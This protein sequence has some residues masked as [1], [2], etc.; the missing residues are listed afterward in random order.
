VAQKSDAIVDAQVQLAKYGIRASFDGIIASVAG[1]TTKGEDV[2]SGTVMAVLVT[3]QKIATITLNEIDIAKVKLGQKATVT[4]DAV[5]DLTMT[6][7]VAEID[8]IGTTTQGVVNYGVQVALDDQDDRIKSGMSVS[9]AIVTDMKPDAL[10][11]PNTAV[12]T[13]NGGR[14]VETFPGTTEIGVVTSSAPRS[15]RASRSA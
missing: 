8:T 14:Y 1:K 4:F 6:G 11:V 2:A 3:P 5:E 12:K 13:S 7:A 15:A 10:L 9:V